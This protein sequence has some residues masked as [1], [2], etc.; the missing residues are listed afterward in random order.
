MRGSLLRQ[1]LVLVLVPV[2]I[3]ICFLIVLSGL[4]KEAEQ[5]IV[6]EYHS[7]MVIASAHD[8]MHRFYEWA[9]LVKLYR[10]TKDDSVMEKC[11]ISSASVEKELVSIEK[12]VAKDPDEKARF[13]EVS[14][15]TRRL[16]DAGRRHQVALKQLGNSGATGFEM[17]E[18]LRQFLIENN[19]FVQAEELQS[20]KAP[21]QKS[22]SRDA[23]VN[24]LYAGCL[25]IVLMGCIQV[26]YFSKSTVS[27][28]RTLVDN[29]RRLANNESLLARVRGND[30]IAH[31][32]SV[33][34]EMAAALVA[35]A[36]HKQEL[37]QM[38]SHDLK[39]PLTSVQM[40]L[41][42]LADG[43]YGELPETAVRQVQI[44]EY[45]ATRLIHLIRD[46]LDIDRLE[47]GKLQMNLEEI[48]AADLVEKSVSAVQAYAD[49]KNIVLAHNHT[50]A[51]MTAD[52]ERLI[53]VI[54]NLLS[55]A[56][57]FSP[58]DSTITISVEESIEWTQ[59]SVSDKGRGIPP[60]SLS[61]IFDRFHQ[62]QKEDANKHQGTGL[63]LAIA[64]AIVE[65]HGGQIGADSVVGEGSTFWFK[66]PAHQ[67]PKTD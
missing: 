42:A 52:L 14:K 44:T 19:R 64:K 21:L 3:Q 60:E 65:A 62:L 12:L 8:L 31:L 10:D 49:R 39:T 50:T 2:S 61:A 24:F 25:V 7:K 46:L 30:E 34:H 57:K 28:L 1:G 51:L 9:V 16:I 13:L 37:M 54:V 11:Q 20:A 43:T 15:S 23:V 58:Q 45:N 5:D 59:I 67:N 32:D 56:V 55:N 47:A 41:S 26:V 22:S 63:G 66:I 18:S 4:L 29:S 36:R 38:V 17:E 33:F 53:Q 40:S 27:R 6:D 48:S 35:A